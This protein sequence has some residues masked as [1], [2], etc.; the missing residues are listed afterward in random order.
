MVLN[1]WKAIWQ[2]ATGTVPVLN[3][4]LEGRYQITLP[5]VVSSEWD[6]DS[7]SPVQ[8]NYTVNLLGGIATFQLDP[9]AIAIPS[10]VVLAMLSS[11]IR[12][13]LDSSSIFQGQKL[14]WYVSDEW[15][16]LT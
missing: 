10:V 11:I 5:T 14:W 6:Q 1:N 16:I 8:N 4:A 9:G 12:G 13:S 7:L 2:Y 3:R 15:D